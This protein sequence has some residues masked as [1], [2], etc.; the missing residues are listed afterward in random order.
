MILASRWQDS[1][2]ALRQAVQVAGYQLDGAAYD[3][4][5]AL[6][7]RFTAQPPTPEQMRCVAPEYGREEFLCCVDAAGQ[8]VHAPGTILADYD[9]IADRHPEYALW[10]HPVGGPEGRKLLI[11]RWLCHLAGFRHRTVHLMLD[12]PFLTDHVLAQ[13]R[14][15]HKEEAPGCFD[16][17]V[18]GHVAGL[19]TIETTLRR[20]C[21]EELGLNQDLIE[22]LNRVGSYDRAY[23]EAWPGFWNVEHHTVFRGRLAAEAWLRVH[24]PGDE[25]AGI[26]VF[27][28]ARLR[29]LVAR[30][31]DRVA[32]GLQDA[33]PLYA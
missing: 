11:A 7:L 15:V 1:V 25:V 9:R 16:L 23:L 2:M 14:G 22:G 6:F 26:A 5:R 24:A 30:F 29:A 3:R 12:H 4:V 18:A 33:L 8:A 17:P 10:F 19:S 31:P 27:S 13:V 21:E 28:V 32:S 20:E